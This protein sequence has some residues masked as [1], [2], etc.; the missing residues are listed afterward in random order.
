MRVGYVAEQAQGYDGWG[1]YTVGL[2]R[3]VKR[4]GIEPVLISAA[5][6]VDPSLEAIE[7]HVVLPRPLSKR[8]GTV[9]SLATAPRL[10]IAICHS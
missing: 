8:F 10:M 7:R 4:L 5:P 2:V 1:R 9:R 3:A 6:E